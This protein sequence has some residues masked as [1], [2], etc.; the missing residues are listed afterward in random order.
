[1]ITK[2]KYFLGHQPFFKLIEKKQETKNFWDSH[3]RKMIVFENYWNNTYFDDFDNLSVTPFLNNISYLIGGKEVKI[4]HRFIDSKKS[5]SYYFKDPGIICD[6]K[7][8][9]TVT[10]FG[11]HG[12][13]L[14]LELPEE[15]IT[16]E[17]I[18]ELCEGKFKDFP[19]ILYFSSCSLFKDDDQFGKDLLKSSGSRGIFG[20]K[21][22]VPF[23]EGT[24]LD[25]TFFSL[26]FSFQEDPLDKPFTLTSVC[27]SKLTTPVPV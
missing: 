24:L 12:I 8:K 10:Y 25:L 17:D 16:K 26:F 14:G 9:F 27:R 18:L 7:E 23:L 2:F 6:H 11:F 15:V 5:L 19:N 22:I 1:M 21:Q 20:M 4:N 3:E 13:S